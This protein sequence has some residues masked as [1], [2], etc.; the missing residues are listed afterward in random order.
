MEQ[1]ISV[2]IELVVL[3]LAALAGR[4]LI[5][6]CKTKLDINKLTLISEWA[7]KFVKTAENLLSQN[8]KGEEK[9]D[10]VTAWLKEKAD[11]IGIKLTEDQIRTLLEDAYTTMIQE[12]NKNETK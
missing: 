3:I 10:M 1:I 11:E 9:R 7:L 2:A 8:G 12:A 5:P 6:F 4:Y